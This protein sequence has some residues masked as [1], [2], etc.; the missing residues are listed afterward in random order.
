[1]ADAIYKAGIFVLP[2]NTE[3]VPNTLIEA[4]VMGLTVISTDCPCGGPAD[5]IKD[6]VNGLLTP[7]GDVD[8]MK[9]NLHRLIK[10]VQMADRLGKAA[11]KTGESYQPL[12]VYREWESFLL[13]LCIK[14]QQTGA[15]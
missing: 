11:V 10:D 15:K 14:R 9:E 2:S 4:M 6:G 5:L 3:G 12:R 7:V 13:A 8:K 1:M